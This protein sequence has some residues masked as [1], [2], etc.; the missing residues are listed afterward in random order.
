MNRRLPEVNIHL[1]K[2]SSRGR[3][4]R[5]PTRRPPAAYSTIKLFPVPCILPKL[6]I[7]L[8]RIQYES[9]G[10]FRHTR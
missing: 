7:K 8:K 6:V 9:S 3:V 1:N 10:S 5:T 4:S 2:H